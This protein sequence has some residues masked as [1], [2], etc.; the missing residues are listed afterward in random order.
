MFLTKHSSLWQISVKK[1]SEEPNDQ[2]N[3][4]KKRNP[5]IHFTSKSALH[6]VCFILQKK[7]KYI[8]LPSHDL[9]RQ[10]D[11]TVYNGNTHSLLQ[12]DTFQRD[13]CCWKTM[14]RHK[15]YMRCLNGV[16][17]FLCVFSQLTAL[18]IDSTIKQSLAPCLKAW[19]LLIIIGYS[20]F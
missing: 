15:C 2:P 11:Y 10:W 5:T 9:L 13:V 14:Q 16:P 17:L 4:V 6:S 20:I 1:Q 8:V 7:P 12:S 3:H 18:L 19:L